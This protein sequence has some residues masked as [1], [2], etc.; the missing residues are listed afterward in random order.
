MKLDA[1]TLTRLIIITNTFVFLAFGVAF[2]A[3]PEFLAKQL[4]IQLVSSTGFAD[5]RAMYGGLP[6]ACGLLFALSLSKRDWLLPSLFLVA[7]SS[8]GLLSGRVYSTLVSG[9]PSATI[10][11]FSAMEFGSFLLAAGCYRALS[12]RDL[13]SVPAE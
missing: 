1:E 3:A 9:T 7:A 13:I 8:A 4:D 2:L 6:L 10:F 5:F 12:K 11:M